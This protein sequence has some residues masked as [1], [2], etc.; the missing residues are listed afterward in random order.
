MEKENMWKYKRVQL[1]VFLIFSM[2]VLV[3]F[4]NVAYL[5][6]EEYEYD[7][8]NR[9]K[10]VSYEDG[11]YVEYEYDSNGNILNIYVY[12]AKPTILPTPTPDINEGG[13][14]SDDIPKEDTEESSSQESGSGDA[15]NGEDSIIGGETG[16]PGESEEGT[17]DLIQDD[18]G[19]SGARKFVEQAIEVITEII[20][21]IGQWFNSWFS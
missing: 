15:E 13:E 9:V 16:Q 14:E 17:N 21:T 7:E 3:L 19:K 12:E 4:F 20:R 8:L 18:E 10:K 1:K 6:A 5:Q 11:S 2:I